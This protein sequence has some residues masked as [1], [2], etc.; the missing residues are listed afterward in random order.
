MNKRNIILPVIIATV[1]IAVFSYLSEG[2]SLIFTFVPAVPIALWLYYKTC[3]LSDKPKLEILPL[4]LLGIGFQLIHF[5]EE[6]YYGFEKKFGPLFG[7]NEYDHNVFVG[8]NMFAYF[9]FMIG[10]IGFYKN[11][12]P[13]MFI[14]M[15]FIVYGMFGNAIG[16]IAY[17]T[18]VKGYFPG[19]FTC[20][21]NFL[22]TPLLIKKLWALR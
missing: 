1:L 2:Y 8:F 15:F 18:M 4:Y 16:H 11:I 17:C 6:H 7:G 20:F 10:A 14:G 22:L 13:L 9:L 12:K 21:L 19:I 5:A 3:Y